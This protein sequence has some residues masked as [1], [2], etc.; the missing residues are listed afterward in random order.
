P[1]SRSQALAVNKVFPRE[2][3]GEELLPFVP[4]GANIDQDNDNR[5]S[6]LATCVAEMLTTHAVSTAVMEEDPWDFMAVYFTAVDHF[7]HT[8]MQYHPPRLPWI[9]ERDFELYKDVI[10]GVY[11]FSDMTLHRM[12]QLAGPDTTVILCSDHGFQ[13]REMRPRA[14]PNE[15]AGPAFWHR[16]FGIFVASGPGIKKGERIYGASLLDIAPTILA[17]FG[18][19]SGADMDGRVLAEIFESPPAP[20]LI[21]SWDSEPG[22]SGMLGAEVPPADPAEG[23]DLLRQFV[24]LGYIEAPGETVEE[25]AEMAEIESKY[26]LARNL[27]WCSLHDEALPLLIELVRRRPW[28]SRFI[29][30]LTRCCVATGNTRMARRILEAAYDVDNS[31]DPLPGL[32]LADLLTAGGSGEEACALLHR[33]EQRIWQP[34][35]LNQIGRHYLHFRKN[36]DAE[37]VFRAALRVHGESAEAWEG[38]SSV[39]CRRGMNQEAADAA[40]T[41]TSLIYRLPRAHLNLGIALARSGD[42]ENAALALRTAVRFDPGLYAAHRW[43]TVVCRYFLRDEEAV[44]HHRREAR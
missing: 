2:L 38:L 10:A 28:E 19:P 22:E 20:G 25:Q 23:G 39:Y 35:A 33:L 5:L 16:R 32:I 27:N 30:Q 12:L 11:R 4:L 21:P 41:A 40:L 18:L 43:L 42:G 34:A 44:S 37:R 6:Q 1:A 31:P 3:T 13:S 24:A 17:C 14:V 15:P 8:F 9:P 7:S 26:N 29:A 36:D